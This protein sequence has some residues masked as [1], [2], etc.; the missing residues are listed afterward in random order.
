MNDTK[1][2]SKC[3]HIKE[4]NEFYRNKKSRDGYEYICKKCSRRRYYNS[5]KSKDG[6]YGQDKRIE[7][8]WQYGDGDVMRHKNYLKDRAKMFAEHGN[9]WWLAVDEQTNK[10]IAR[11]RNRARFAG[12][13]VKPQK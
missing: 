5:T 12:R 13:F 6:M 2:C 3:H 10:V 8:H 11:S 7:E 9:G 1:S 4:R